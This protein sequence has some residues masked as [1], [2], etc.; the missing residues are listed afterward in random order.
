VLEIFYSQIAVM[1]VQLPPKKSLVILL[2]V[3]GFLVLATIPS[4]YFY[5]KY[6]KVQ[7][8]LNNPSLTTQNE[9]QTLIE[10]VGKLIELPT[11]E[12]PTVATVSD[13]DKLK[14][15][16]FFAKAENGDKVLIFAQG[17]KAILYRPSI[18]KIIE[19]APVNLGKSQQTIT[20]SLVP[21]KIE[22]ALYNGTDTIG[23]TGKFE[24]RLKNKFSEI[25][26]VKKEQAARSDYEKTLVIDISKKYPDM[27]KQLATELSA[28]VSAMP[29]G[30]TSPSS[31][32]LIIF[33]K[34]KL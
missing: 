33:G 5:S 21:Q 3:V 26:I 15:Q 24:T 14:D 4:Y 34:D 8:L 11:N 12:T 30:E 32:I 1:K 27:V 2:G 28:T 31:D 17:G 18:N 10:K 7:Q 16:P 23:L 25:D 20:P 6:Q 13:K 19:V 9:T 29:E 22:V